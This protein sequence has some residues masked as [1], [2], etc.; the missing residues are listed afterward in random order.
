[1]QDMPRIANQTLLISLEDALAVAPMRTL[2]GL[3]AD[4]PRARHNARADLVRHLVERMQGLEFEGDR[5]AGPSVQPYL[6]PGDLA[7]LG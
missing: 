2:V 1:M 4:D 3:D 5:Y 6:F 7:P